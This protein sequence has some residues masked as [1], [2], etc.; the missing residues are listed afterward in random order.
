MTPPLVAARRGRRPRQP[1]RVVVINK[2]HDYH[3]LEREFIT[4][5]ISIRALCRQHGIT[6]H[7]AVVVQARKGDWEKKRETYR[8]RAS[9][10][11]IEHHAERMADRQAEIHDE[12]L[13]A[14]A[15]AIA[16]FR[17]DLQ[18]TKLVR[19]PDGRITEEP[20]WSMTPRD[21][22][23][24][25][26]RFQVLFARPSSISQHQGLTG[27]SEL[28]ADVLLEYIEATRGMV[29]PPSPGSHIPRSPRRP[30]DRGDWW[31]RWTGAG[32]G[33]EF[34]DAHGPALD[35]GTALMSRRACCLPMRP[36]RS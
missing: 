28:T 35:P 17:A 12:V 14:I 23:L 26:D 10:S 24:I 6:A 16:R 36:S 34:S 1:E 4:T 33:G 11:F 30:D 27:T 18:A 9:E 21:V 8:A 13:E 3:A 31:T 20:A 5:D 29:E 32:L 19:Q 2:S 7:S 15:E 25:I 22:C